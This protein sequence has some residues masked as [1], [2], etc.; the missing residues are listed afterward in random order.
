MCTHNK[1]YGETCK[2][3]GMRENEW[4][5]ES[6]IPTFVNK[7][8]EYLKRGDRETREDFVGLDQNPWHK[9]VAIANSHFMWKV[10]CDIGHWKKFLKIIHFCWNNCLQLWL[11]TFGFTGWHELPCLFY[12]PN[13][14]V[15]CT[16]LCTALAIPIINGDL[17][18]NGVRHYSLN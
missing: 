16:Y 11:S 10:W 5:R 15:S 1:T 6:H 18:R 9:F 12:V 8:K 3:Q 2:R 4:A 17:A 7:C 13:W 14:R